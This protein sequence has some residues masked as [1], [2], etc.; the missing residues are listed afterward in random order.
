MNNNDIAEYLCKYNG[1]QFLDT[2][3]FYKYNDFYTPTRPVNQMLHDITN[4]HAKIKQFST[5]ELEENKGNFDILTLQFIKELMELEHN[6]CIGKTDI[7]ID[8]LE[9]YPS[10]PTIDDI[11]DKTNIKIHNILES[12]MY[13]QSLTPNIALSLELI[14]NIHKCVSKDLFDNGGEFRTINVKPSGYLYGAY[15]HFDN[16]SKKIHAL[17]TF[18]NM[19]KAKII[20]NSENNNMQLPMIKLATV[21]FCEFLRIHPFKNGNGRTARLLLQYLL[22]EICYTPFSVYAP[23]GH[24]VADVRTTYL[25]VIN[26]AQQSTSGGTDY[27]NLATYLLFACYSSSVTLHN[28]L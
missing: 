15:I 20:S 18:W 9:S 25:N 24:T 13:L 4:I 1:I 2:V 28:L 22:R 5:L 10:L 26:K 12:L 8:I 21:F 3:W 16:I 17:I 14:Q 27:N 23:C 6:I 19:Q 7:L 11:S